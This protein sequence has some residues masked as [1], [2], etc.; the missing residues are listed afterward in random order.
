MEGK[1]KEWKR[2]NG[3]GIKRNRMEEKKGKKEKRKTK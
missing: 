1:G 3:S 2:K